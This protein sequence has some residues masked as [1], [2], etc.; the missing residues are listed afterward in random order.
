MPVKEST[1]DDNIAYMANLYE[2]CKETR[3]KTQQSLQ[4][5]WLQPLTKPASRKHKEGSAAATP[6]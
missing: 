5:K 3:A 1:R 2:R 6:K 4:D